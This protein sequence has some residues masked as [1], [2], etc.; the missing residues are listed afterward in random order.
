MT[1][2]AKNR[3]R[4]PVPMIRAEVVSS[5]RVP[6]SQRKSLND[7]AVTVESAP[8]AAYHMSASAMQ[9]SHSVSRYENIDVCIHLGTDQQTSAHRFCVPQ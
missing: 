2:V 8:T 1:Q 7:L 9:I 5:T 6:V 4:K 3:H